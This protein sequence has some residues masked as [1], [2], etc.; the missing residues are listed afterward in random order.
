MDSNPPC[1]LGN[2]LNFVVEIVRENKVVG[3][4]RYRAGKAVLNLKLWCFP[5]H[6]NFL[7]KH[8]FKLGSA[9]AE[10]LGKDTSNHSSQ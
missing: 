6:H 10:F 5:L 7:H 1:E 9:G 2:H 4:R 3:S 8:P